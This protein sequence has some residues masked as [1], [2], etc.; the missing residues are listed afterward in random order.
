MVSIISQSVTSVA[1]DE[2]KRSAIITSRNITGCGTGTTGCNKSDTL[3]MYH[4]RRILGLTEMEDGVR[5]G[6][7]DRIFVTT[8][9]LG[10]SQ[11]PDVLL[12][13]G[14]SCTNKTSG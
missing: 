14:R 12:E 2:R 4:R 6:K 13:S 7:C 10:V 8:L 9:E 5:S 3:V 11:F 1:G